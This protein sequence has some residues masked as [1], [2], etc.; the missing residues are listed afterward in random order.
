MLIITEKKNVK[1]H[2]LYRLVKEKCKRI[3]GPLSWSGEVSGQK[4]QWIP[5]T[6]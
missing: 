1:K 4:K 5:S 6:I 2:K 3:L